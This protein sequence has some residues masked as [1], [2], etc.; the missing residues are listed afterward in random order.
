MR[1]SQ[2]FLNGGGE[3]GERMRSFD[4]TSTPLGAPGAWPQSLKTIVRVML[5]SR[6]AMWMAWGED[7][8]FFCNDAYLPTLG[9]KRDWALGSRADHVWQEIWQDIG[10][11]IE[12]V[13]TTG[14]ATWDEA[15]LLF[16]RRSGYDEETFHTFSYSPVYS[17]SDRVAGMLCV[18]VE[19]TERVIGE[20]RLRLLRELAALSTHE[21]SSARS[22]GLLMLEALKPAVLDIP[23]AALY[24]A[25]DDAS[26]PRLLAST[27]SSATA[28]MAALGD[29]D[30]RSSAV[31]QAIAVGGQRLLEG[32]DAFDSHIPGAWQENVQ[33][34]LV[35]PLQGA[36]QSRS[37]GAIVLGISTRRLLDDSYRS[38]LALVADQFASNLSEA[39]ARLAE[40]Q[41]AEAL[42]ELDR[43]KSA[44][45][46]NVSHEFR[47]PLTLMLGPTESLLG[48][49]DLSADVTE[50]LQ[51]VRRNGMRLRK[52]VNSLLD[53]SRIEA[54][55]VDARYQATNLAS[56]TADLAAVFR[57]AVE[58]AGLRLVVRCETLPQ[59]AY[60]D[61]D[62]WERVVL[63]LLSN[64][65]KFTFEGE[66]EVALTAEGGEAV[67]S[68]RDTG[69]GIAAAELPHVFDRFH[70]VAGAR[71][72]SQEGTGIGLALV[73]ELVKLHGG[74]ITVVS[75]VGSGTSFVVRIPLG[76]EHLPIEH[77]DVEQLPDSVSVDR[78][79]FVDDALRAGTA[80]LDEPANPG[81]PDPAGEREHILVVDDNADMRSYIQRLL[82]PR[83]RVSTA[84][85]GAE[86]LS[87][88][89]RA[90]PDLILTD[91]MMPNVD[92]RELI[93]RVRSLPATRLLPIIVLSAEAGEEAR[94]AGLGQGADDYLVKPFSAAELLA[95]VEVQIVRAKLRRAAEA[96]NRQLADVFRAAPV[97]VALLRGKD[98]VFE[99]TNDI[100]NGFVGQREVIGLPIRAAL[101]ELEDQGVLELLDGVYET[102]E[103]YRGHSFPTRM[104]NPHTGQ[105]EQRYFE[106]VFQ[107]LPAEPEQLPGIAVVGI[108][109]SELILARTAAEAGSRAKDE[110]IAMLG[111]E[112][113]NPLAPIVTALQLMK[114]RSGDV[115]VRE[116]EIIER[117]VKHMV[118][119]VD[120]LLDVSRITRGNIELKRTVV[121]LA[122]I[123]DKAVETASPLFE[124]KRQSLTISVAARGLPVLADP[125]RLCQI[126]ANLLTNA[127]NFTDPGGRVE[128]R[129]FEQGG[130]VLL[131]VSDNGIGLSSADLGHVFELFVQGAQGIHRPSGGLGLG[132]TIARNLA[133]LHGGSLSASSDGP[134]TGSEFE[135]R[136]PLSGVPADVDV[137]DEV[138]PGGGFSEQ[139][140]RVLVVD[141]SADAVSSL[142]ELLQAL[143]Y[144]VLVAADG[145]SALSL[146]ER[147]RVDVALLDIGLPVMDGYELARHIRMTRMD[148]AIRLVALTG[149]GHASDQRRSKENGF[150]AHLVKP[151]E[152]RALVQALQ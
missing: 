83:W 128:V 50:Q 33:Q 130:E 59:S 63:N 55:R 111:H 24:L 152:L 18:V 75:K 41:R 123:V 43:A 89:D 16:L 51:L 68:I 99:F 5:D 114:M 140:R 57:S 96:H 64:A 65:F 85:D 8:I 58:G 148:S 90:C 3:M 73:K 121:E 137:D 44:F 110:F 45:F 141:D 7:G 103:A 42:A 29:A 116:R 124:Q 102:Q 101:P 136:L 82:E 46:N 12:Q 112:L 149:Y 139:R 70:R 151:V 138:G 143:G 108:D 60:V 93:E 127:S 126:V 120:D 67:L 71:S 94:L 131:K 19:D 37:S 118:R 2:E 52:L 74:T 88:L 95:R 1:S 40:R 134:G 91:M 100:Y 81:A 104:L 17:E 125:V 32:L 20:R 144:E 30:S 105:L 28:A 62:M 10:P 119:L 113:R 142:S 122:A 48:R 25:D 80:H 21:A 36:Y 86:A 147:E 39:R 72:R 22:A 92:G 150:S 117:Q 78:M 6:F 26:Q 4:W 87:Q 79:S 11:R 77:V 106:F 34:A 84:R 132:L 115:A 145:P 38:F 109:I 15:L 146:V 53:F 14:E 129:A 66:I 54:G 9:I 27:S 133:R 135:L 47:T 35:L 56:L 97:G 23:F 31:A 107:P 13:L 69:A 98:H 76:K 61:R 49:K